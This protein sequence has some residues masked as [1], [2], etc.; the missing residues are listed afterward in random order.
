MC[1]R[2]VNLDQGTLYILFPNPEKKSYR[3]KRYYAIRLPK[4]C[5]PNFA[6]PRTE[7]LT[8]VFLVTE[9]K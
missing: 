2:D 7:F 8:R 9:K 6:V 5:L 3:Q 1:E 4:T